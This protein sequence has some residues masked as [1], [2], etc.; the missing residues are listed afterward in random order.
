MQVLGALRRGSRSKLRW[1][2]VR[3]PRVPSTGA[4]PN[5]PLAPLLT[6]QMGLSAAL[7]PQVPGRYVLELVHGSGGNRIADRV[8]VDAVPPNPLVRF[9]SG[10]GGTPAITVGDQFYNGADVANYF[11]VLVLDRKTLGFVSNKDYN[12]GDALKKDLAQ[13]NDS[14]LVIVVADRNRPGFHAAADTLNGIGVPDLDS[15]KDGSRFAAVG[16]PG[17]KP[18]AANWAEGE[19]MTGRMQGY[20]TPDQYRNYGFVSPNRHEFNYGGHEVSPCVNASPCGDTHIGYR[21]TFRQ[22][23]SF[24]PYYTAVFDTNGRGLDAKSKDDEAH[25][26]TTALENLLRPGDLVTIEAVSNRRPGEQAYPPPL[27]AVSKATMGKL[28]D[29]IAK[30]GGT[31]NAFNRAAT[32]AGVPAS[33]GA[34]YTLVGW[35]GAKE[36]EG[37]EVAAGVDGNGDVPLLSGV[38]R[39][40][41]NGELRPAGAIDS[42]S[43]PNALAEL[44]LQPPSGSWP[45]DDDPGA[46][47]AIAYL[48]SQDETL[49]PDPRTAYWTQDLD[50]TALI[51]ELQ[52]V[53]YPQG[54]NFTSEQFEAA[55]AELIKELGW[56]GKVRRY[57]GQ[58]A[59][60]FSDN[61]LTSWT[62][63]QTIADRIYQDANVGEGRVTVNWLEITSSILALIPVLGPEESAA[64]RTAE[65]F[66]RSW[67][68]SVNSFGAVDRGG[69]PSDR[70]I[71]IEANE[72]GAELVSEAQQNQETLKRMGDVI[73]SDYAKLSALGPHA[74]CNA[75]D[76]DCPKQWA[77]SLA[78]QAAASAN[79]YLGIERVAYLKLLPVGYRVFSLVREGNFQR[80]H[81]R[82]NP[83]NPADYF[84]FAPHPW[85]EYPDLARSSTSLLHT[86]DPVDHDN[87]WDTFVFSRFSKSDLHGTPPT[88]ALL[89]R[90]FNPLSASG[91]PKAGGLALNWTQFAL[92]EIQRDPDDRQYWENGIDGETANCGWSN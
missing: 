67:E 55:R 60:P 42:E 74:G 54:R 32:V 52:A 72:V 85:S 89:D 49:G 39:P 75:A 47:R 92:P 11:Q 70:E 7:T 87:D 33:G 69:E 16:V 62:A 86:L 50:T 45:L 84:C 81:P 2:V 4:A 83:P 14:K 15:L 65:Q 24:T 77:F 8:K 90:M 79:V 68:F 5:P 6:S 53:S 35:A 13:L 61:A 66:A 91:N 27:G 38:L 34:V 25:S 29:E 88:S 64:A 17:M 19:T 56:V 40:D 3:S 10:P 59:Q 18:G 30:L 73:V 1:K 36:G 22:P 23:E 26:M 58:L 12:S 37:A 57:L 9:D 82:P 21:V 46:K 28:T 63:A 80:H 43:Q 71:T 31:R 51:Q 44:T 41:R 48:G 76:P 20:L 78:D